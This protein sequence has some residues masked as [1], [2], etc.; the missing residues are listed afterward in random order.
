MKN[1]VCIK[2]V[3]YKR[4]WSDSEGKKHPSISIKLAERVEVDGVETLQ[5]AVLINLA[6]PNSQYAKQYRSKL[7]GFCSQVETFGSIEDLKDNA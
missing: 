3:D 5:N 4:P 1:L 7:F 6:H 2:V